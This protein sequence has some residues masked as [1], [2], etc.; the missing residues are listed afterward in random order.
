PCHR[1][2]LLFLR[3]S[4]SPPD[5]GFFKACRTPSVR[6]RVLRPLEISSPRRQLC[7][8]VSSSEILGSRHRGV[9]DPPDIAAPRDAVRGANIRRLRTISRRSRPGCPDRP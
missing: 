5:R 6:Q 9:L 2:Y 7:S 3:L 4:I 1:C 8:S